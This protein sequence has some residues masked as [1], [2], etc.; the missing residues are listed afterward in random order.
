M[1]LN[2]FLH[3]YLN[4]LDSSLKH[5]DS[6]ILSEFLDDLALYGFT[7]IHYLFVVMVAVLVM[8]FTLQ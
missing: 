8:Q 1:E 3:N 7:E 2:N 5:I 6:S 4:R